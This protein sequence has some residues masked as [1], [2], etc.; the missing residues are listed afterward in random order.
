MQDNSRNSNSSNSSNL[1]SSRLKAEISMHPL[2]SQLLAA[3]VSCL[4]IATPVDQ[5][6]RI[7]AQ[8]AQAPQ[9]IAKYESLGQN[10]SLLGD[11]KEELDRFMVIALSL[12]SSFYKIR[13]CSIPSSD[14]TAETLTDLASHL[15]SDS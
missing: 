9:V 10:T 4:R 1:W 13:I 14:S 15:L 8:I 11:E 5:L 12:H 3:H 7:D 6:P 2:Y